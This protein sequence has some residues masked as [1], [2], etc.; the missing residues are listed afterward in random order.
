M[1]FS[2]HP[3]SVEHYLYPLLSSYVKP[4]FVIIF[5][6]FSE[7]KFKL[8]FCHFNGFKFSVI[9]HFKIFPY[10]EDSLVHNA[11]NLAN[12]NL[13]KISPITM[14]NA[15]LVQSYF[16]TFTCLFNLQYEIRIFRQWYSY[17]F[18]GENVSMAQMQ[19]KIKN[20]IVACNQNINP[21]NRD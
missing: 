9:I 2:A 7:H 8:I 20:S 15:R 17:D 18:S 10:I 13:D 3:V 5:E 6:R 4:L 19:R 1:Y 16:Y 21:I 14:K 12:T 11:I